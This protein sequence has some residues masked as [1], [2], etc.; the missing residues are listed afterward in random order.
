R[1][2]FGPA[3]PTPT[4]EKP[5]GRRSSRHTRDTA[6]I[7]PALTG[8]SPWSCSNQSRLTDDQQSGSH[9]RCEFLAAAHLHLAGSRRGEAAHD[10]R[11]VVVLGVEVEGASEETPRHVEM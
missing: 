9:P 2:P 1:G 3:Q 5:G 11:G 6:S 4:R 8:P 7:S 10:Q